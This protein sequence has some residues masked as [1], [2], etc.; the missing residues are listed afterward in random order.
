MRVLVIGGTNF[1]GPPVVAE[2][3]KRGHDVTVFHRGEHERDLGGVAHIHG[4]RAQIEGFRP[5]FERLAPD[6]VLDMA[7]MSGADAEAVLAACRGIARRAVAISSVDVYRAYGRLH[8]SEPGPVEPMPLT[9]DSPMRERLYPYRGERGGRFDDYDKIPAERAYMSDE[10]LQGTVLRL[11]AVHGEGDYQ[12]RLFLEVARFDAKR[13]FILLQEDTLE[14]RWP[15][16]YVGN[17]AHAIALAVTDDRA[18]G[19]TYNAPVDPP[20]TQLE[21]THACARIAGWDGEIVPAPKDA[22]PERLRSPNNHEQDVVV[23]DARI[24]REL[25]YEDVVEPDQGIRRAMAWERSNPPEGA[26]RWLDFDAEDRV[27]AAV[28]GGAGMNQP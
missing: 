13:P 7:P 8:G 24:R 20:L 28:H 22:L 23:D 3:V 15:R 4:D 6:V 17:V 5:Q 1:I 2:L 12:H 26:G 21:W 9:E 16:A 18:A 10:E 11:P 14:W 27:Y 19:R 25:G